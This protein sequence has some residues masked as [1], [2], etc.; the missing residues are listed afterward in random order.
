MPVAT[1]SSPIARTTPDRQ[2]SA[3][4]GNISAVVGTGLAGYL[5]D[6]TG[7]ANLCRMNQPTGVA[8]GPSG[9]PY[10]ADQLNDAVRKISTN[11]TGQDVTV[12]P[13]PLTITA[14]SLDMVAGQ[15][16]P[17]PAA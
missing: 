12:A 1:S 2:V 5:G 11:T 10:I 17:G 16:V 8:V 6:Q 13:A 9:E 7:L 14:V 3:S 15:S 4:T